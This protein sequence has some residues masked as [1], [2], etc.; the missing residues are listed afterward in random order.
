MLATASFDATTAV[1]Q[2]IGG[3]YECISTWRVHTRAEL[4]RLD[5][6]VGNA[7]LKQLWQHPEAASPFFSRIQILGDY[8]FSTCLIIFLTLYK[9]WKVVIADSDIESVFCDDLGLILE[10]VFDER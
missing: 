10:E 2:N 4:L 8:D 1:W 6:L 3:D 9:R 5:S 7:V